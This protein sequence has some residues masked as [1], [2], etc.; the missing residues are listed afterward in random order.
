M[1]E[2]EKIPFPVI[3]KRDGRLCR[4]DIKKIAAAIEKA[5]YAT[6]TGSEEL[7]NQVASMVVSELAKNLSGTLP[8]VEE[9][10]DAVEN[11]LLREGYI[12]TAKAYIL[13]RAK[14]TEIRDGKSQL[15]NVVEEIMRKDDDLSSLP[16]RSPHARM[17]QIARSASTAFYLSRVIPSLYSDA[18]R[19]GEI[20]INDSEY[21]DKT[22]DSISLPITSLLENGFSGGYAFLKPPK[23][24]ATLAAHAA[25]IMQACQNEI[26]GEVSFHDFDL[27]LSKFIDNHFGN[28]SETEIYQ[29]M[30]GFIYNLNTL[31]SKTAFRLPLSS[32]S[33]GKC[34]S[35][36]GYLIAKSILQLIDTGLG[37]GET[38]IYPEVIFQVKKG[39][40]ASP[41]DPG[42]ELYQYAIEVATK[43]MKPVFV[44]G[45]VEFNRNR[46]P[47]YWG[48]GTTISLNENEEPNFG[49]LSTVSINLT[50]AAYF[51]TLR[52]KTFQLSSFYSELHRVLLLAAELMLLRLEAVSK[53]KARNLP[54]VI[55]EKIYR[56]SE[57]CS[58]DG[59]IT[60]ALKNGF[61]TINVYG[62][63]S[64]VK[65]LTG[66]RLGRDPEAIESSIKILDYVRAILKEQSE[67]I[68][69]PIYLSA[70]GEN[71]IAEY[72]YNQDNAEFPDVPKVA[73][74]EKYMYGF[75]P[76]NRGENSEFLEL[77]SQLYS[78]FDSG[79]F[80]FWKFDSQ[81]SVNDAKDAINRI[82]EAQIPFGGISFQRS[83]CSAC[84]SEDCSCNAHIN[85]LSRENCSLSISSK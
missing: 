25:I 51:A 22:I 62:L 66:K 24:I 39:V 52:R 5:F 81:P 29:A 65:I 57:N 31:Y 77:A 56:G 28:S 12:K 50:R 41:D 79:Q 17:M 26:F 49:N 43:R 33:I 19:K 55:G 53:L 69:I 21:Y 15:M 64:A 47:I 34:N 8:Q 75:T 74:S 36:T 58:L 67:K 7:A 32:I 13:Y 38:P 1:A 83:E 85:I 46:N 71:K 3:R 10:Q 73:V 82:Q 23:R 42:Y 44:F 45:D 63:D 37:Q 4:F 6:G 68:N 2:S 59:S 48:N 72:F 11:V 27:Y 40:N 84:G 9:I 20:F 16:I 30:E 35:D 54:F 78:H 76:V 18:H 70:S 60:D 14:R 80:F 61:F